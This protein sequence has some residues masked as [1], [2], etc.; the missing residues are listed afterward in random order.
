MSSAAALYM[1]AF[2]IL[3]AVG[4]ELI[5]HGIPTRGEPRVRLI[6]AGWLVLTIGILIPATGFIFYP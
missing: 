6:L 5:T 1:I 3:C 4:F 2:A